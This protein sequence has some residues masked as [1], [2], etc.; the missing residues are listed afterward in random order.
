MKKWSS[1]NVI[2]IVLAHLLSNVSYCSSL[3]MAVNT[4]RASKKF[5]DTTVS[6]R[7]K[8]ISLT[9]LIYF[10]GCFL[11]QTSLCKINYTLSFLEH[12]SKLELIPSVVTEVSKFGYVMTQLCSVRL[13]IQCNSGKTQ[14]LDI[15]TQLFSK[16][17]SS[18]G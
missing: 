16:I 12:V 10:M 17:Q 9:I 7:W 2:F 15:S 3:L 5:S 13:L 4:I 8:V 1:A 11:Q 14:S 18:P 6:L